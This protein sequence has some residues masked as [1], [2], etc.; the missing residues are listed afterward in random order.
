MIA[1]RVCIALLLIAFTFALVPADAHAL[2]DRADHVEMGRSPFSLFHSALQW[3]RQSTGALLSSFVPAH[4]A[5][6]TGNGGA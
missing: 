2:P 6:I 1:R 4:G 5:T 3:L